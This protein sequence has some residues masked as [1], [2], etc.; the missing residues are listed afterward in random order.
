M[1]IHC[2]SELEQSFCAA[3]KAPARRLNGHGILQA[4]PAI[5]SLPVICDTTARALTQAIVRLRGNTI[6]QKKLKLLVA[7][8][9]QL[10]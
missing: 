1:A 3:T 10:P 5:R 8:N 2:L 6:T 9:L 4:T 7:G